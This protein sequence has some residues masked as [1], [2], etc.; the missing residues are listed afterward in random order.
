MTSPPNDWFQ[1][2]ELKTWLADPQLPI[3]S[4]PS[5]L[6]YIQVHFYKDDPCRIIDDGSLPQSYAHWWCYSRLSAMQNNMTWHYPILERWKAIAE[7]YKGSNSNNDVFAL[8]YNWLDMLSLDRLVLDNEEIR[9]GVPRLSGGRIVFDSVRATASRQ[10]TVTY[11]IEQGAAIF[12]ER[13]W[14]EGLQYW[15]TDCKKYIF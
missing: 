4:I 5:M 12:E 11:L 1:T 7:D 14:K 9:A 6:N 10:E 3:T 15:N 2:P 13:G 8:L